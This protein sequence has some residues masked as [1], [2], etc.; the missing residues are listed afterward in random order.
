MQFCL[1]GLTVACST[2]ELSGN[3]DFGGCLFSRKKL[4]RSSVSG[5]RQIR[6]CPTAFLEVGDATH[7][8][9]VLGFHQVS[10]GQ[11]S[12]HNVILLA[13]YLGRSEEHTSELQSR[14]PPVCPP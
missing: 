1:D 3:G 10:D 12:T 13:T 6:R 7:L 5:P 11:S 9:R 2:I 4:I 14:L 8:P